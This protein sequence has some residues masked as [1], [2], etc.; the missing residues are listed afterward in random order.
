MCVLSGLG[1]TTSSE[2]QITITD[3]FESGS[4]YG[5][6]ES[7]T[8]SGSNVSLSP[9]EWDVYADQGVSFYDLDWW[10]SFQATGVQGQSTSFSISTNNSWGGNYS[11][12]YR[13]VW[14]EYSA[15]TSAWGDWNYFD[16]QLGSSS[17]P[18]YSNNNSFTENVIQVAY[19]LPYTP[20]MVEAHTAGLSST[21]V[22]PTITG[23]ALMLGGDNRAIGQTTGGFQD[24][25][26]VTTP[27]YDIPAYTI[28][29]STVNP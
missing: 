8:I 3:Q 24:Y 11:A 6:I 19:G 5:P 22:Q 27:S 4:L 9:Y 12:N 21:Y 29:D 28:T 25:R 10:W 7:A 20:S 13:P 17:T 16:N 15:A 1:L 14:R 26:G 23:A 18:Q 2:G